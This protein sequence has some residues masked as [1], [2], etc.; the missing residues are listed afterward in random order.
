M[1][2]FGGDI[3]ASFFLVFGVFALVVD[4]RYVDMLPSVQSHDVFFRFLWKA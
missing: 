1:Q 2:A 3:L 4:K